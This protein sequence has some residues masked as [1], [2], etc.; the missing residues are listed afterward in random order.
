MARLLIGFLLILAPALCRGSVLQRTCSAA[1]PD[2]YAL[3]IGNSNYRPSSGYALL[4][5]LPKVKDDATD[6]ASTLCA[7]GF[8]V[9]LGLDQT[10]AELMRAVERLKKR[11]TVHGVRLFY[12]SG[13][14]L[15]QHDENYLI[16]VD[17]QLGSTRDVGQR[18]L[19]LAK[20]YQALESNSLE[21][22]RNIVILDACRD[23]LFTSGRHLVP[24]LALPVDVPPGTVVAFATA[25]GTKALSAVT[26]WP[27]SPYTEA[28][29]Q[30]I[31]EPG[32]PLSD[33]FD[34][35]RKSLLLATKN[36]QIPWENSSAL[37]S[38]YLADPVH[39]EWRIDQVDDL[40]GIRVSS[41]PVMERTESTEWVST[42]PGL[43]RP[44]SNRF[45][46][47]VYNDK[48][49]RKHD[50]IVERKREGWKYSVRLR[51]DGKD[52]HVFY[53]AEDEPPLERWGHMF[54]VRRGSIDID[55]HTGVVKVLDAGPIRDSEVTPSSEWQRNIDWCAADT[56][57]VDC[58]ERYSNTENAKCLESG[59]RRCLLEDAIHLA[60]QNN[61]AKALEMVLVCQCHNRA[62]AAGIENAGERVVCDY[63][64]A[65]P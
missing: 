1:K 58:P 47:F 44:G 55:P 17:A 39:V 63:L 23:N 15:Q 43:L 13:H 46:V 10:Q 54:T 8:E 20:V 32:L 61:C 11:A 19:N 59:G 62:V 34:E 26:G 56:G 41:S 27:H 57:P 3:V 52:E 30:H 40:V 24:G 33:L 65:K 29:L 36:L 35:V 4:E 12:Y 50:A 14:A 49:Y 22:P 37:D 7:L 42:P 31:R 21:T 18:T 28:I 16:P 2:R 6:M 60:K 51:I 25:P 48:T 38:I 5:R 9:D 45:E 64:A 53:D